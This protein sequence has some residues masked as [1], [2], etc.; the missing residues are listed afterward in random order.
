MVCNR[1]GATVTDGLKFCTGCGAPIQA[2]PIQTVVA[3]PVLSF[4]D[5]MVSSVAGAQEA[6]CA[7]CGAKLDRDA[8]FCFQCGAAVGVKPQAVAPAPAPGPATKVYA[9]KKTTNTKQKKRGPNTAVR[10]LLTIASVFLCICLCFTLLATALVLDM[11]QFTNSGN[12]E[13]VISAALDPKQQPVRHRPVAGATG[14]DI[15]DIDLSSKDAILDMVMEEM[16]KQFGDEM[17]VT[18]SQMEEFIEKSTVT[19]YLSEKVASY[20][21]DF[22]NGT[23]RTRITKREITRLVNDNADLIES[24][25][26]ERVDDSLRQEAIDFVEDAQL[27]KVIREEV[28]AQVSASQIIAGMTVEDLLGVLRQFT[29]NGMLVALIALDLL[30]VALLVL[31]NWLRIP[32]AL[33]CASI[34]TVIVGTTLAVPTALVQLLPVTSDGMV[35]AVVKALI[36]LVAPVHYIMLL[37][38]V[39]LL[40]LSIL[41][42]VVFRNV[43]K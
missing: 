24:I 13:K 1:C 28:M 6:C 18:R 5:P 25:F 38:G 30:L 36:S 40:I 42:K 9:A 20:T 23:D 26:H 3:E 12:L 19:E 17:K 34:S 32:S 10:V 35:G 14:F 29:S 11:R 43:R 37:V 8:S 4:Q 31:T 16:E 33:L 2:E 21:A 41:L 7:Q 15:D 39:L 22:I 27:D